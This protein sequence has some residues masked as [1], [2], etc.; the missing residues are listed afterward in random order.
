MV[1]EDQTDIAVSSGRERTTVLTLTAAV[2]ACVITSQPMFEPRIGSLTEK[3]WTVS[4][5]RRR[6]RE[7]QF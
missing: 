7:S 2:A 1:G 6:R 5:F 4:A 3:V